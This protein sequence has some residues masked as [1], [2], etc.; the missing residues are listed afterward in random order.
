MEVYVEN[1]IKRNA[2]AFEKLLNTEYYFCLAHKGTGFEVRVRFAKE[3]FHHLEGIGQLRDLKI[4]SES[5][6]RTFDLS[7][8]GKVIE[9]ELAKSRFF[10][11][12][13][14]Q[15]KIDYL[16]NLEKAFDEDNTV[17]R[18]RKDSRGNTRIEAKLLITTD[19]EDNQFMIYLD[20]VEDSQ[21]DYF[22]KSFVVN[23]E[24]DRTVGQIKLTTLWK[25]KINLE[26]G[27]KKVL[28]RFK[29]FR[30]DQLKK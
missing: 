29:E 23:P 7:L 8:S 16:Y 11:K 3:E 13:R 25:E 2:E 28:Y 15:N 1:K 9:T 22:C 10:V 30:P 17:F 26:N 24:F 21:S 18:L 19:V 27:E 4:H 14:V 20:R 12:G 6:N 5:G